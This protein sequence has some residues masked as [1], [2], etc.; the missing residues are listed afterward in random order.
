[1]PRDKSVVETAL[2]SKG[3]QQTEGDH[4]YFIY[5]RKDGK[6]TLAKTKTSHGGKADLDDYLLGAMAK[7]C[8]LTKPQFLELVDCTLTR[9]AYERV[10][11]EKDPRNGPAAPPEQSTPAVTNKKGKK[12]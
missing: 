8:S 1:M 3:F 11:E 6:K 9:D 10:L 4:H 7:Q 12:R 5:H 2:R